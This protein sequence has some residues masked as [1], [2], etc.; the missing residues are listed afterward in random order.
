LRRLIKNLTRKSRGG[1]AVRE[2]TVDGDTLTAG[3]GGDCQIHLPDP[4][5]FLH[6]AEITV[7]GGEVHVAAL[8]GGDLRINGNIT[9]SGRISPTD[10]LL[11]G[12]YELKV[13]AVASGDERIVSGD[14]QYD[15]VLTV[16]LIQ[17]LGDDL[18]QLVGRARLHVT[19]VGLSV[20]GWSWLLA[21]IALVLLFAVPFTLNL[22]HPKPDART[23]T[24]VHIQPPPAPTSVW[25]S[26]K[27][28][29][30][31]KFFGVACET[32]HEVPFIPVRNSACLNCHSGIENHAEQARFPDLPFKDMD[33]ADCHKEHH[34]NKSITLSDQ[35][36]CASCHANLASQGGNVVVRNASDFG[37]DHPQFRPA[38]MV[39]PL[40][41]LIRRDHAI[42][43]ATPPRENNGLK[44]PHAKH[45]AQAGVR[46]PK[47]GTVRLECAD[48]H[49]P[50]ASGHSMKPVTFEANCHSCHR[51]NFDAKLPD[52]ELLHG[53]PAEMFKQVADVYDAVAMRGGYEDESAPAVVRRRPGTPLTEPGRRIAAAWAA[54]KA[55]DVSNG[56]FGKGL[57]ATCH[58]LIEPG[59]GQ[60]PQAGATWDVVPVHMDVRY[61]AKADFDHSRHRDVTCTNCHAAKSSASASDV[62]IMGV[63]SCQSCHGGEH[64]TDRVPS[65]CISCHHFHRK[66][67]APLFAVNN[68]QQLNNERQSMSEGDEPKVHEP[69]VHADMAP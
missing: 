50:D 4:R 16:E 6:H 28:S 66:D 69:S 17:P 38:V 7:R 55:S 42:G 39:D 46:D 1:V 32:C 26:G 61:L 53:K 60:P 24:Q 33:C 12:P 54:K 63:E 18:T 9:Q 5:V 45:L 43:D 58:T 22:F 35:A 67:M 52:R 40:N 62:L 30:S 51:L 23:L 21:S 41:K 2:E 3:R 25:T 29:S 8:Q 65:T 14:Q 64:A 56:H 36:F 31:H 49:E 19:R 47:R 68:T 48:C 13:E 15:L 37:K 57:C 10:S 11:I 44:F 59:T 34:G 20:R 27:I